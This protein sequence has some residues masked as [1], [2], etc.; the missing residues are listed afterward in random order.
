MLPFAP[1]AR[2]PKKMKDRIRETFAIEI[3]AER[4]KDGDTITV[5]V[6]GPEEDVIPRGV[7]TSS[8]FTALLFNLEIFKTHM[9]YRVA[10]AM[11]EREIAEEGRAYGA[12]R[13]K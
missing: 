9:G 13:R 12:Y 3:S 2:M 4:G 6:T 5:T 11:I 1:K 7:I 10:K 8:L